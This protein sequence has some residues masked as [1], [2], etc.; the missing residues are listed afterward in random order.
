MN[1]NLND[2]IDEIYQAVLNRLKNENF[3]KAFARIKT[4]QVVDSKLADETSEAETN[5]DKMISVKFAF[6][7]DSF[8]ALN[9]TG[10]KLINGDY[11]QVMYWI[12]LKNAVIVFKGKD[13]I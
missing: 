12:D 8:D 13:V 4:A 6:D 10:K 2:I 5:V 1:N 3:F 7:T 9:Y 11:V